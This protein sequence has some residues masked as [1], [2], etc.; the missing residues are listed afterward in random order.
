MEGVQT[1]QTEAI[2]EGARHGYVPLRLSSLC[3]L[4][5]QGTLSEIEAG[6]AKPSFDM[7]GQRRFL[8]MVIA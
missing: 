5:Q 8:G 1:A 7:G 6:K 3:S 4:R 2:A